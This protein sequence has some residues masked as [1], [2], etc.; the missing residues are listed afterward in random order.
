[1]KITRKQLRRIINEAVRRS[2][3]KEA[4]VRDGDNKITA[5]PAENGQVQL[6]GSK[7]KKQYTCL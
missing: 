2:L 1:M 4:V 5:I 6:S 3:I 7:G